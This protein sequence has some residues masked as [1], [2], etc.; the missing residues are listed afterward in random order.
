MA[1]TSPLASGVYAVART[2]ADATLSPAGDTERVGAPESVSV[3]AR[4]AVKSTAI[5]STSSASLVRG[6]RAST[7]SGTGINQPSRWVNWTALAR[8]G[9]WAALILGGI[10]VALALAGKRAATT[11]TTVTGVT[12]PP[13]PDQKK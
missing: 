12:E 13:N 8:A 4:S 1:I 5:G 7:E 9:S 10:A 11:G 2:A 3:V 6:R